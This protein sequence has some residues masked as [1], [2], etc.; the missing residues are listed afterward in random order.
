[1]KNLQV[2]A[3]FRPSTQLAQRWGHDLA[4]PTIDNSRA[5]LVLKYYEVDKCWGTSKTSNR[6]DED[7]CDFGLILEATPS[8]PY[9]PVHVLEHEIS[10]KS[11]PSC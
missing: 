1:M 10:G 6:V 11:W 3:T 2:G 7:I 9:H 4:P 5:M 8:T